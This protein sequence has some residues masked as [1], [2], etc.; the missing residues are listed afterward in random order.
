MNKLLNS[1]CIFIVVLVVV[2]LLVSVPE[3]A[4]N[5]LSLSIHFVC[6]WVI[7]ICTIVLGVW[8]YLLYFLLICHFICCS[9]VV[10]QVTV[11]TSNHSQSGIP[12]Y[13]GLFPGTTKKWH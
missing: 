12:I 3:P 10:W 7:C 8:T 13:A 5:T 1:L 2:A 11:R 4:Q 6:I 9:P